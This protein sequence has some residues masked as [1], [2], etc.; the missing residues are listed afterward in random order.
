MSVQLAP[1]VEVEL[2]GVPLVRLAPPVAPVVVAPPDLGAQAVIDPSTLPVVAPAPRV[3]PTPTAVVPVSGPEGP[4]G[5]P[6]PMGD[7]GG[8]ADLPDLTLYFENGLI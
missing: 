6:G 2:P 8:A 3:P 4:A 5:P 1:S 7:P